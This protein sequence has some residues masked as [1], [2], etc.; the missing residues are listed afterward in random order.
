[1]VVGIEDG[2][3]DEE[4]SATARR[5]SR[6]SRNEDEEAAAMRE[7]AAT[8]GIDDRE[9]IEEDA[10]LA[11]WATHGSHRSWKTLE[12]LMQVGGLA[13]NQVVCRLDCSAV[14]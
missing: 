8:V 5:F 2:S 12:W 6:S 4:G 3:E 13:V 9:R 7:V 10:L 11:A 1:M 14:P